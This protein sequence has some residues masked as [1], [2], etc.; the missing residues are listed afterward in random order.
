M[1]QV[2]ERFVS[3]Q[4]ESTHAG[5]LC[6][7]IRLAGCNLRCRY[8]DTVY[9]Q[10][11][12]AG[13]IIPHDA[14]VNDVIASGVKLAEITGGEP[15]LHHD[16]PL[17]CQLLLDR[18]IEVL[19]ETNGSCPIAELPKECKKILDCKLP[20]SGMAE[21]NLY[22]NYALLQPHDE[23]KFVVSS[24]ADFDFAVETIQKYHLERKT[25]NLLLSPVWGKVEF[26]ELADWL[27]ESKAPARLQI[28]LH[29]II[30]G[31][32]AVGK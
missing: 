28:Q 30:W 17:L 2:V 31:K 4:G 20:D 12:G 6:Y 15:L 23:V 9:A 32:D 10:Q 19:I 24:R 22:E 25:P 5:R 16:L 1:F 13:K 27:L 8:C 26:A 7:F 29:K 18:G 3:I 11:H 21:Y 14:I